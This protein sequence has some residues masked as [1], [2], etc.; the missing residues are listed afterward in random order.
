MLRGLSLKIRGGSAQHT[1]LRAP[2]HVRGPSLL[3]SGTSEDIPLLG[4]QT[5]GT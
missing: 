2:P 5:M 4:D 1:D 3:S